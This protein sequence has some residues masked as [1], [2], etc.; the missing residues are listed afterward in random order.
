MICLKRS[1]TIVYIYEKV[2]ESIFLWSVDWDSRH[3]AVGCCSGCCRNR[4]TVLCFERRH[5]VLVEVCKR[6]EG[7]CKGLIDY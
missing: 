4:H 6:V 1:S 2:D 7:V 3:E 5:A